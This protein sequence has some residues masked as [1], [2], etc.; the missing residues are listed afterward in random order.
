VIGLR[1]IFNQPVIMDKEEND[2]DSFERFFIVVFGP[3][4][5]GKTTLAS[6]ILSAY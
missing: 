1:V 2:A 4:A 5:S 3:P 6:S